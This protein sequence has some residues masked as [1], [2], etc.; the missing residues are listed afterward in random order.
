MINISVQIECSEK[1]EHL[2]PHNICRCHRFL[3]KNT[4]MALTIKIN[5]GSKY[6]INLTDI[7]MIRIEVIRE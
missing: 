6:I 3:E 5:S 7:N 2:E 1:I 4:E